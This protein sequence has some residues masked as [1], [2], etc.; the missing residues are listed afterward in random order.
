MAGAQLAEL[1]A[2]LER[3]AKRQRTHNDSVAESLSDLLAHVDESCAAAK[4]GEDAAAVLASLRRQ[5]DATEAATQGSVAGHVG[6]LGELE[7]VVEQVFTP[8][9]DL[10]CDD[11]DND[12]VRWSRQRHLVISAI[13]EHLHQT[14]RSGVAELLLKEAS[15]VGVPCDAAASSRLQERFQELRE[16][17]SELQQRRVAA[18]TDWSVR[19]GAFVE[20]A[21][22]GKLEAGP[23]LPV[24]LQ[25]VAGAEHRLASSV[26]VAAAGRRLKEL[27]FQLC[28]LRAIDLL[29]FGTRADVLQYLRQCVAQQAT[30]KPEWWAVFLSLSGALACTRPRSVVEAAAEVPLPPTPQHGVAD[31]DGRS[32][33]P[34]QPRLQPNPR[35]AAY[36][37]LHDD[38]ALWREAET[39]LRR[40]W[41]ELWAE[42]SHSPLAVCVSAGAE[43]LPTLQRYLR[44]P[45]MFS[46]SGSK[47]LPLP[48]LPREL[49]FR[50]VISCPVTQQLCTQPGGSN[51]ALLLPCGHV[52]SRRAVHSLRTPATTRLKCPYCPGECY[53]PQCQQLYF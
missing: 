18:A 15:A 48:T 22:H 47:E 11:E 17:C 52:I 8:P 9:P 24:L 30:R 35:H 1:P 49:L 23:G 3:V 33:P 53:S 40:C 20:A 25:A 6:L 51:P 21:A 50:S 32:S 34:Q 39:L 16:L 7:K 46:R 5:V 43:S 19:M 36:P 2:Q 28:R 10:Y 26:Q 37:W 45:A 44:L 14:G 41:C 42:P 27:H 29:R 4:A 13:V 31:A 12:G 38:S